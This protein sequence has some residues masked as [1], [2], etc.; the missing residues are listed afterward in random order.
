[1]GANGAIIY[2]DIVLQDG[3]YIRHDNERGKSVCMYA[4]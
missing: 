1:M 3:K 4:R 2:I